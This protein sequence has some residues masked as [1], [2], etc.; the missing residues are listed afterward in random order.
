MDL[1]RL[2]LEMLRLCIL[3]ICQ[4]PILD[5]LIDNPTIIRYVLNVPNKI[6]ENELHLNCL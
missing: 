3:K 1:I 2:E 5:V 4:R 6:L